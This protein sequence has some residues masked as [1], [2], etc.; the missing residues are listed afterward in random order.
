ME[1][2]LS[3]LLEEEEEKKQQKKLAIVSKVGY[4]IGRF[5]GTIIRFF[6]FY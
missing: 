6:T 1:K 3:E 4:Y 2:S 5:I